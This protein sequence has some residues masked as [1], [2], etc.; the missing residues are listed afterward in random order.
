VRHPEP[1][2]S[3]A[4]GGISRGSYENILN[5]PACDENIPLTGAAARKI[6]IR[7]LSRPRQSLSA[8]SRPAGESAGTSE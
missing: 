5:P 1:R 3:S 2:R 7:L 6:P 4:E 8:G